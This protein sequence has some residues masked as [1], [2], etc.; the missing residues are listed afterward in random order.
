MITSNNFF[1]NTINPFIRNSYGNKLKIYKED[2]SLNDRKTP[3]IEK[4]KTNIFEKKNLLKK[5]RIFST[6]N[7]TIYT[8]LNKNVKSATIKSS[9]LNKDSFHSMKLKQDKMSNTGITFYRNNTKNLKRNC[10]AYYIKG[11]LS[12]GQKYISD[13]LLKSKEIKNN[14]SKISEID[15]KISKLEKTLNLYYL[16]KNNSFKIAGAFSSFPQTKR[17]IRQKMDEYGLNNCENNENEKI[18]NDLVIKSTLP[19]YLKNEFNIND[20]NILSPFCIKSRDDYLIK[21][22]N[23]Y[24]ND[25]N[26]LKS[27]KKLNNKLNIIYAENEDAYNIKLSLINK[28]LNKQGKIN[29]YHIGMSPSEKLLRDIEKKVTLMKNIVDYA[30]PNTTLMRMRVPENKKYFKKYKY[31]YEFKKFEIQKDNLNEI[32]SKIYKIPN[33][34]S[35]TK[36][37]S[38]KKFFRT[39]LYK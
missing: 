4:Y 25:S 13:F 16:R 30:Y 33:G 9:L 3:R 15:K 10:S 17:F 21:K 22:F 7:Q 8:K 35:K 24:F 26:N 5:Q 14:T 36:N 31:K 37:H 20:T 34:D 18:K 11:D 29:K 23:K 1:K 27:D 28:K 38:Y 19:D 12:L 32:Q 39:V 2:N 6:R